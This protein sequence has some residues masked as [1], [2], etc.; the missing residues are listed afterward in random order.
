M[1]EDVNES[2]GKSLELWNS[3]AQTIGG[4][5]P[6]STLP[7]Q[8]QSS[9]NSSTFNHMML[10]S[11]QQRGNTTSMGDMSQIGGSSMLS[12]GKTHPFQQ[13]SHCSIV[14]IK[15]DARD[16]LEKYSDLL[17]AEVLKKLS[18]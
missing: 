17:M 12:M 18:K 2:L 9:V 14:S 13:C 8:T 11:Q 6:G 7:M 4:A 15:E 5:R 1:R 16:L 10:P 3:V